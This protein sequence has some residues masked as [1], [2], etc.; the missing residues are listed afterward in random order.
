MELI[1]IIL[2]LLFL[3]VVATARL[4]VVPFLKRRRVV[5]RRKI[6][7]GLPLARVPRDIE[8]QILI[9][10]R[11]KPD[12]AHKVNLRKYTCTCKGF[13]KHRR[14]QDRTDIRRLCRHLRKALDKLDAMKYMDPLS[15]RVI[16]DR[17][18]DRCYHTLELNGVPLAVG[19]NAKSDFVRVFTRTRADEDPK[20]GPYTGP[21]EK[22]VL[23]SQLDGWIYGASPPGGRAIAKMV[24]QFLDPLRKAA[25]P[26]W[27]L[28]QR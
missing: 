24:H 8:D 16:Q 14:Y 20:E 19:F 21:Y 22:F 4:M 27:E 9:P 2:S 7:P 12:S 1:L 18:R 3:A 10:S 28:P 11:S 25:D 17:I 26:L 13:M 6:C 5:A 15:A 23:D